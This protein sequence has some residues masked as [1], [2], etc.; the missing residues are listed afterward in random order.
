MKLYSVKVAGPRTYSAT[1]PLQPVRKRASAHS[2][3]TDNQTALRA[4]PIDP[5]L[6]AWLNSSPARTAEIRVSITA[7]SLSLEGT[8]M[9]ALPFSNSMGLAPN[10]MDITTWPTGSVVKIRAGISLR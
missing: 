4:F 9:P 2:R 7:G 1:P 6:A 5:V 10:L 3:P 8:T